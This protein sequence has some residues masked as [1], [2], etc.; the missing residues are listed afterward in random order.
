MGPAKPQ[1]NLTKRS[2]RGGGRKKSVNLQFWCS[3]ILG[4]M[5]KKI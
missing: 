5:A 4:P 3:V 1:K 2:E